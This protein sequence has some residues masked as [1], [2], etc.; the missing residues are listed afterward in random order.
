M[1]KA[2][3]VLASA[4]LAVALAGCSSTPTAGHTSAR[5]QSTSSPVVT[6]SPTPTPTA[7]P[8]LTELALSPEGLGPL[9]M[10]SPVPDEPT[11][12]AVVT[13]N[14]DDCAGAGAWL[15]NYPA[16]PLGP[17]MNPTGAPFYFAVSSKNE[18]L[19]YLNV[20]G[21]Q[22][23]TTTGISIGSTLAQLTAAYPK[24]DAVVKGPV[25]T[26]YALD[27]THAQLV[28]E[29]ADGNVAGAGWA[30]KVVLMELQ[31]LGHPPVA[32]YANDAGGGI[33]PPQE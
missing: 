16:S 29:V 17:D 20:V 27:G 30:N 15:P 6:P 22:V 4:V 10:G 21:I 13:W 2:T 11:T 9:V 8:A 14:Q 26:L 5:P 3:L 19:T 32:L 33:C 25:T 28:I 12:S 31:P 18:P 23:H 1:T 7:P 24:F